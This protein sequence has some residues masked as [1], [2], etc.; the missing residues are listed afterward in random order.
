MNV[1]LICGGPSPERGISLNSAR[2]VL[3]HL[4]GESIKITPIYFDHKKQPYLISPAQLYSN[5]PS[6]FDFK[7]HS[8][9][10]KLNEKE[11]TKTLRGTDIVF[12]VMHG[13][14]GEDGQI[15]SFL[16][17]NSIPYI[18]SSAKA[19]KIAFDKFRANEFIKQHGFFTLPSTVLKIFHND[20]RQILESFFAEHKITRAIVK[21]ATGG[22]SIGV[23]SVGNVEEA[24]ERV[25]HLFSKRIDTRVVV[26][27][28]CTGKEFTVIILQNRFGLPVAVMP[29]EIEADY[30]KHQIFDYRKKYLPTRQVTYHCPPRFDDITIEKIQ[31]QAEQ[32]F[33]VFGMQDY[34]R[35]D[36]WVLPDGTVWFSDFNPISG[37]EQNSFLFQ[38]ASR[39]GMSHRDVVRYVVKR[40]C[41]RQGIRFPELAEKDVE[42]RLP[43]HVLFGGTTSERQVSLMSG[44]NV[45]L[46]L[47]RSKRYAPKP[48]LLD[49]EGFVWQLPYA[50]TLNHTVEEVADHARNAQAE[51]ERLGRLGDRVKMRLATT[52]DETSESF[53]LPKRQTLAEFIAQAP[54]VFIA[55]HGGIGENG[56]LQQML[57]T[58]GIAHNGSDAAASR[59]CMN[60]FMTNEA[61]RQLALPGVS[62]APQRVMRTSDLTTMRIGA[63]KALWHELRSTFM[64]KELITKPVDDGCSSGVIRLHSAEELLR[65]VDLIRA[66]VTTVPRGTFAGQETPIDMPLE[67]MRDVLFEKYIET[68][69]I[70]VVGNDLKVTKKSG[71]TE[72]TVGVVGRKGQ[73]QAMSP[74]LTVAEGAV[75]SVEEKFQGGT[76]VNI[77]PPPETLMTAAV[78]HKVRQRIATVAN[79]LE[80]EGYARIDAF[81]E[82]ATGDTMV[83]EVNTLPGLT[84]STVIYHQA[85]AE[86]PPQFP[87]SFLESVIQSSNYPA[88]VEKG[89][90]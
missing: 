33:T 83:I 52:E 73:M 2:S 41:Q 74:S 36:G 26:E 89:A 45:W 37:M 55:L 24:L 64:A 66:K 70:R 42:A 4:G 61:I 63:I 57:E 65:Y 14:F 25:E 72:V 82:R 78:T 12:P 35:F 18:G 7:L 32:L 46:K 43:V 90:A 47:R 50:L 15:Q 31:Y 6:D 85:L 60:K 59:L 67:A 19:C 3:D 58:S 54:Y 38:Q 84:P 27:P 79:A 1:A 23:F 11:L 39:I 68:D 30:T 5:T 69:T 71:W 87:T 49:C 88:G 28:F 13:A 40:S 62:V 10:T 80:L 8:H 21:P 22:S 44:T 48:F 16:E 20:H 17:E 51:I 77:T 53:F 86:N 29:T 9:A 76:G 34:A 56:V 81:I 75:L